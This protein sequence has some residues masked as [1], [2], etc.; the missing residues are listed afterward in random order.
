MFVSLSQAYVDFVEHTL[1]K[2]Y[3]PRISLTEVFIQTNLQQCTTSLTRK[4]K[5]AIPACVSSKPERF[6][7]WE[8]KNVTTL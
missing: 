1:Y 8:K 3:N 2:Y 5:K 7:E 4:Y 6:F